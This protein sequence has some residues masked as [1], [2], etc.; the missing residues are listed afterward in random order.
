MIAIKNIFEKNVISKNNKEVLFLTELD[1][2]KNK[3]TKTNK[4]SK[5][6][7][8]MTIDV[9]SS[10]NSTIGYKQEI[11][12]TKRKGYEPF[13][14]ILI[15]SPSPKFLG[16]REYIDVWL[17][18]YRKYESISYDR[19]I[20]KLDKVKEVAIT[21]IKELKNGDYL[22]IV[23]FNES[24][25]V[26]MEAEEI[27][28]NVK[29]NAINKIKSLN[30]NGSTN[31]YDGWVQAVA[32]ISKNMQEKFVNRVLILTDGETNIGVTNSNEICKSVEKIKN[33]Y[34]TTT[35]FGIGNSFNEDLLQD[36]VNVGGGNFYYLKNENEYE[37][38]FKEEF[39]GMTNIA[40]SDIKIKFVLEEGVSIKENLNSF[41]KEEDWYNLPNVIIN[42]KIFGLFKF[43]I[44]SNIFKNK[45]EL[46]IGKII[47]E[48]KDNDSNKINVEYS[49]N[50][51]IV[52]KKEYEKTEKNKEINVQETLLIIAKNKMEIK[53]AIDRGD[54][55]YV[56]KIMCS[57]LN[58]ATSNIYAG[59]D[60]RLMG[61]IN[62]LNMLRNGS[63]SS[64]EL[65]KSV[66][67]DSYRTR[68][69]KLDN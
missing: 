17:D 1:G 20:S 40:A 3:N 37:N 5:L 15:N 25:K 16:D 53:E 49:L 28:D 48:Y 38:M 4:R 21:A 66:V 8:C 44:N 32:E 36:I 2:L 69:S 62:N 39:L 29:I 23:T 68:Y 54:K 56:D 51:P 57:S 61:E 58:A 31:L 43:E 65:R 47:F 34:I 24:I 18:K 9:S 27:N 35:C 42:K 14:S 64:S 22:S 59:T 19:A 63:M 30:P 45:D 55:E 12:D 52:S 46:N 33:K 11:V 41:I 60:K 26:I 10:M 7:I 6:N 50:I 67:N 13:E